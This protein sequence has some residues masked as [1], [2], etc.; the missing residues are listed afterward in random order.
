MRNL[1][2]SQPAAVA[3]H[4]AEPIVQ[5]CGTRHKKDPGWG[6]G[7]GSLYVE[8][9]GGVKDLCLTPMD[10]NCSR[11]RACSKV[12]F[13]QTSGLTACGA[14]R[15]ARMSDFNLDRRHNQAIRHEIAERLQILLSRDAADIPRRLRKL[16]G[17]LD[18][19]E[20]TSKPASRRWYQRWSRA[21]RRL[22]ASENP[23]SEA[24]ASSHA[25]RLRRR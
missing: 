22:T 1:A 7:P 3:F 13:P 25:T 17:R 9:F 2:A 24:A 12:N 20:T 19:D 8:P 4:L 6:C 21:Q 15:S 10:R 14:R 16:V 18:G 23:R 5:G 11:L